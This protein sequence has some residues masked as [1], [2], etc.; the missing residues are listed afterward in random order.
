[1][2]NGMTRK[3]IL[4]VMKTNF[5]LFLENDEHVVNSVEQFAREAPF[6]NHSHSI[7]YKGDKYYPSGPHNQSAG[8][9]A[10]FWKTRIKHP[11]VSIDYAY[12]EIVV[13]YPQRSTKAC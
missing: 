10:I 5:K 6:T 2:L 4:R 12:H 13:I 8:E 7:T 1:M 11:A 3:R 9:K